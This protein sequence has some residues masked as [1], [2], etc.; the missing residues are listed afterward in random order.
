MK[1]WFEK[2]KNDIIVFIWYATAIIFAIVFMAFIA[3]AIYGFITYGNTT[4][5]EMPTWLWLLIYGR[6]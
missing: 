6:K 4:V 2:H 3:L 1:K 5:S